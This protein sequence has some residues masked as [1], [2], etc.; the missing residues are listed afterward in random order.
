MLEETKYGIGYGIATFIVVITIMF[1]LVNY[2]DNSQIA[3]MLDVYSDRYKLFVAGILGLIVGGIC[4]HM[5]KS[6]NLLTYK[7]DPQYV[8]TFN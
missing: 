4:Y 7:V 2:S 6:K 1:L 3:Q 5:K 8:N